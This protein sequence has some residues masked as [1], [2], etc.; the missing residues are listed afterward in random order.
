MA[1]R[2]TARITGERELNRTLEA[3]HPKLRG[4]VVRGALTEIGGD[5]RDLIRS[6]HL[7][8]PS[9]RKLERRTGKTIRG[10]VL[11]KSGLG[12]GFVDVG[13]IAELWWLENYET[14]HGRRG[15]R[16]WLRPAI[17]EIEPKIEGIFR[18]HWAREIDRA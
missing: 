11:D 16:P 6:R 14:G 2:F 4:K 7:S 8:G 13:S 1:A 5:L 17:R 18:R 9:P 15:H 3:M 10:I 12:R